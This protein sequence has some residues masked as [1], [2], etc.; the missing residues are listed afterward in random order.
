VQ[1]I[2]IHWELGNT[3]HFDTIIFIIIIKAKW[4]GSRTE[5]IRACA[6][7]KYIGFKHCTLPAFAYNHVGNHNSH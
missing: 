6:L 7:K 5:P 3:Y 4:N 1:G 2:T